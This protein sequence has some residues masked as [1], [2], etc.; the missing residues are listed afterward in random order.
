M[1]VPRDPSQLLPAPMTD[2]VAAR[3]VDLCR[4]GVVLLIALLP[5]ACVEFY[6]QAVFSV[7]P[8]SSGHF[9]L[10]DM[11]L[12]ELAGLLALAVVVALSYEPLRIMRKGATPGKVKRRMEV[13]TFGQLAQRNSTKRAIVRYFVSTGACIA[14]SA[15]AVAV[16]AAIGTALTFRTVAGLMAASLCTVWCSVLLSAQLR[17][18]RRGW[19]DMLAGTMLVT[20]RRYR[21]APASKASQ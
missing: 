10:E 19:H 7:G 15:V 3:C 13:R 8:S 21:P 5:A 16:S 12:G 17:P 1:M 4:T 20:T 11:E 6:G 18:D 9:D 2:R 14:S